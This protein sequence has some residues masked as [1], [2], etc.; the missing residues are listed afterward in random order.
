M[1]KLLTIVSMTAALGACSIHASKPAHD[2]ASIALT[3]E[4]VVKKLASTIALHADKLTA[5]LKENK[6]L[7]AV[8]GEVLETCDS[9]PPW[10]SIQLKDD[11]SFMIRPE[12]W[13]KMALNPVPDN[14]DEV[15][16]QFYKQ[17]Q[18]QKKSS[19]TIL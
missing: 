16:K 9:L 5:F 4:E 6:I 3:H 18:K 14:L 19:C 1:K 17:A 8:T 2:Q 12:E 13:Q 15:A 7:E 10:T 11:K